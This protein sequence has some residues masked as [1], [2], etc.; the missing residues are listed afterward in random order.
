MSTIKV[1]DLHSAGSNLFSDSESYMHELR[2][3]DLNNINGGFTWT[4]IPLTTILITDGCLGER[5]DA[6]NPD[7]GECGYHDEETLTCHS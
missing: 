2:D 4:I 1:S 6:C 7:N 5:G 3:S